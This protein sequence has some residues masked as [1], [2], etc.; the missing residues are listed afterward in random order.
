MKRTII[1]IISLVYAISCTAQF[2]K[3]FSNQTL[4][5]DYYRDG[6]KGK[7][8]IRFKNFIAKPGEW[9]GSTT[10]L[11]DPFNYGCMFEEHLLTGSDEPLQR[12]I[13]LMHGEVCNYHELALD[14]AQARLFDEAVQVLTIP[15]VA[16]QLAQASPLT[17]YY[18]GYF[19]QGQGLIN[20]ANAYF[21][22]AEH[23]D[24]RYCF[25]N[26]LEDVQVLTI[27]LDSPPQGARAPYYLGC[28]YYDKRQYDLAKQNWELSAQRDAEFPTVWRNL[29]LYY[30]NKEK[31]GELDLDE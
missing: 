8:T 25:P 5:V 10:H 18:L 17:S 29:A 11:I 2:D 13:T 6:C 31:L 4:R 9:A 26:R 15:S 14:Y 24:P 27:A 23:T 12:L 28:L 22:R 3:Y 19:L 30:Y 21:A 7:E 1:A 16:E 20:E